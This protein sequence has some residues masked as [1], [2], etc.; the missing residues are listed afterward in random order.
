MNFQINM[1]EQEKDSLFLERCDSM[2]KLFSKTAIV[3]QSGV[4]IGTE[5][6]FA[7]NQEEETLVIGPLEKELVFV[8]HG[9]RYHGVGFEFFNEKVAGSFCATTE[10]SNP[11]QTQ[12]FDGIMGFRLEGL[13]PYYQIHLTPETMPHI[14]YKTAESFARDKFSE[15]V[16]DIF[17]KSLIK[18]SSP[19]KLLFGI[20]D[21][22]A[23]TIV[24]P[25]L[26]AC[27]LSVVG[28]NPWEKTHYQM[29]TDGEGIFHVSMSKF[30]GSKYEIKFNAEI[31]SS[32]SSLPDLDYISYDDFLKNWEEHK[33]MIRER[34]KKMIRER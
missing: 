8:D 25:S 31:H 28:G 3:Y 16:I 7:W 17:N 5:F 12:V 32:S 2:S 20:V 14:E 1:G 24:G 9:S 29:Q 18:L 26:M 21:N 4:K 10:K 33:K 13:G 30:R 19:D 23:T 15:E 34:H 27:S 6:R 11:K 22:A